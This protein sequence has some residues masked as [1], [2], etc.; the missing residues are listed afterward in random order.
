MASLPARL[1][2]KV[3]YDAVMVRQLSVLARADAEQFA[4]DR[5]PRTAS[6]RP[7]GQHI[8]ETPV[9]EQ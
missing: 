6:P 9:R 1:V 7:R 5:M 4:A 3:G 2:A 8:V